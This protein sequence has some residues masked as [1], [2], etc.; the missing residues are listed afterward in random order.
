MFFK[1]A[2][3]GE[4]A[5]IVIPMAGLSSRFA[6]AGY[7]APKHMLP[8]GESTVFDH[9][10]GSFAALFSSERFLF[11]ARGAPDMERFIGERC[12]ALGI[13]R[14]QTV[15]LAQPTEGQAHTVALGVEEAGAAGDEPLTVFNIDTFRP[16]FAFPDG[17]DAWDGYLEV[18]LGEG[19]G[20][21]F[22]QP[23]MADE[24]DPPR[25]VRTTEK[26]PISPYCCTGLYHFAR[27]RDFLAAFAVHQALPES[28]RQA[29]ELYV[30]PLY[31]ELVAWG[32]DVRMRLI[33]AREVIFCGV[34]DEYEAL[35]RSRYGS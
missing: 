29:G 34:P 10:V 26:N 31:N 27:T 28:G 23:D 5:V 3:P 2:T 6:R 11:V 8:L 18:F 24:T 14:A 15:L 25:V 33:D 21:S 32:R 19:H 4:I 35:V 12:R 16:G 17:A 1:G 30:A 7:A 20:W 13:R 9:A 22:V